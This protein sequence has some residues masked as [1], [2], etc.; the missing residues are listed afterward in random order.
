MVKEGESTLRELFNTKDAKIVLVKN[1]KFLHLDQNQRDK[2]PQRLKYTETLRQAGLF[3]EV[4]SKK[5]YKFSENTKNDPFYNYH[6]DLNTI[7]PSL[8]FPILD[9]DSFNIIA[10]FQISLW[11]ETFRS[12]EE[13][14]VDLTN[15]IFLDYAETF[16]KFYSFLLNFYKKIKEKRPFRGDWGGKFTPSIYDVAKM[17]LITKQASDK[18]KSSIIRVKNRLRSLKDVAG[19]D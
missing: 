6:C 11:Q 9:T 18:M 13:E 17:K 3:Y 4:F 19:S 14:G 7:L 5:R 10:I 1:K 2:G 8:T 15:Q 16:A 12:V